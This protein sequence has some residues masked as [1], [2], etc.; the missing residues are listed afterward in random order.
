MVAEGKEDG[1]LCSPPKLRGW[2]AGEIGAVVHTRGSLG[3]KSARGR[4]QAERSPVRLSLTMAVRTML[5]RA[6]SR[7]PD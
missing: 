4:V 1:E 3:S 7:L 6:P 5:R 2:C